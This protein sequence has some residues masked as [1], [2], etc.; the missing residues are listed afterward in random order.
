[1]NASVPIH[2]SRELLGLWPP[3][4]MRRGAARIGQRDQDPPLVL[5]DKAGTL[6]LVE[7]HGKAESVRWRPSTPLLDKS[8]SCANGSKH[9]MICV[10][11]AV[12]LV[13]KIAERAVLELVQ[14]FGTT[15]RAGAG[16]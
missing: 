8:S 12:N 11:S 7:L 9:S 16:Q 15:R 2:D 4:P 1:M 13:E 3:A 14:P 5:T 6:K 10:E